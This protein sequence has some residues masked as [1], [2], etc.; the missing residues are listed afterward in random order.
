MKCTIYKKTKGVRAQ[1]APATNH[2]MTGFLFFTAFLFSAICSS[3]VLGATLHVPNHHLSIQEA[4][5][6]ADHGD[7]VA[8]ASGRYPLH[9]GNIIIEKSNLTLKS[10]YGPSKTIIAGKGGAPVIHIAEDIQCVIEGFTITLLDNQKKVSTHGGGIHCGTGSRPIITGNIITGNKA[11]FGGG[12]Y[13]DIYASATI[14]RNVISENVA[15]RH[16]GGVFSYDAPINVLNND[17]IKNQA[18][19]SGGAIFCR[20]ATPRVMNNVIWQNKAKSGGGIAC[21]RSSCVMINNT[22]VENEGVYGGGIY[23]EG[24]S[25][26][27]INS[28][29]WQNKDDLFATRFGGA[30]RPDHSNIGDGDFRGISGNISA[31]PVFVAPQKGNFMLKE[32][33]P[34]LNAG[35]DN[36]IYDDVD[37]T[38]N[39]MGAFGGPE[40][41]TRPAVDHATSEI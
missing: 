37:G 33:S 26:R 20:K 29:L 1:S 32:G 38:R 34:C 7:I 10:V 18:G 24:G 8:V 25:T 3:A 6:A 27:I 15:T 35:N 28:I 39:D 40:G 11:I 5:D 14:E 36:L 4:I 31:D 23:F 41:R 2:V 13:C 30:S 16:G 22:I 19:H 9:R 17:I 21:D 12:I